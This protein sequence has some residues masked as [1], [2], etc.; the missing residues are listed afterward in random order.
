MLPL[1]QAG[2]AQLCGAHPAAP[3]SSPHLPS[4]TPH[5]PET[6]DILHQDWLSLATNSLLSKHKQPTAGDKDTLGPTTPLPPSPLL[7]PPGS[8]TYSRTRS[9]QLALHGHPS[10]PASGTEFLTG[11]SC[12]PSRGLKMASTASI[13]AP[14]V[15]TGHTWGPVH[16]QALHHVL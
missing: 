8:R 7:P 15:S 3:W 12:P 10:P 4:C 1:S 13:F 16:L 2:H 14:G 9:L 5:Q 11:P 6:G